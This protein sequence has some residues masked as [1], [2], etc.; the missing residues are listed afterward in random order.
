MN[1]MYERARVSLNEL[2]GEINPGLS[3]DQRE[4]LTLFILASMEGMTVFAG[5]EKPWVNQMPLLQHLARKSFVQLVK[6]LRAED[7]AGR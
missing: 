3:D 6:S 5:Y 1:E 7:F 2:I 4:M